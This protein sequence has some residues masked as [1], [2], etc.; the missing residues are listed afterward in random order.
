M[1]DEAKYP[2][3]PSAEKHSCGK[4][5]TH[6]V[7]DFFCTVQL[8][9]SI[10]GTARESNISIRFFL[11]LSDWEDKMYF[12]FVH[13]VRKSHRSVSLFKALLRHKYLKQSATGNS[14]SAF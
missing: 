2:I 13:V 4:I 12:T 5:A 11:I 3:N 10:N 8:F 9:A 6:Y 1:K 14:L 7:I